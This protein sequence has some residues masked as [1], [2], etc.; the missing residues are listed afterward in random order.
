MPF[1]ENHFDV[2]LDTSPLFPSDKYLG[3]HFKLSYLSIDG[4]VDIM[5]RLVRVVYYTKW[6]LSAATDYCL[7]ILKTFI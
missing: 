7:W 1:N 3:E 5:N 6:M 2:P 4:L